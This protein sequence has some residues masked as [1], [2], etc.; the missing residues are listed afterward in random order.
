M[1]RLTLES[2]CR[3]AQ[4]ELAYQAIWSHAPFLVGGF[5]VATNGHV[6]VWKVA[7]AD[8]RDRP[9]LADEPVPTG[10]TRCANVL[11]IIAQHPGAAACRKPWPTCEAIAEEGISY[12]EKRV[13]FPQKL[14]YSID[15]V[16]RDRV[17]RFGKSLDA[18]VLYATPRSATK[19]VAFT[20]GEYLGLLMPLR[21]HA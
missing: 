1:R 18:E 12:P 13:Y 21:S 7:T 6:L 15:A 8:D 20:V 19:P 3:D 9:K 11:K 5:L 4:G 10:G 16:Y 2:F 14:R 17:A